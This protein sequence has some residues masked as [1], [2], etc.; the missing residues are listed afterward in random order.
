MEDRVAGRRPETGWEGP[1]QGCSRKILGDRQADQA[2]DDFGEAVAAARY[3]RTRKSS[4]R[5][6]RSAVASGSYDGNELS[7]K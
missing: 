7:A 5:R 3:T 1:W 6:V 2:T 4:T